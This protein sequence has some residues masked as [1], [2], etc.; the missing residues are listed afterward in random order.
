[1]KQGADPVTRPIMFA[2]N[3]GPGSAS[4]WLHM[5]ILG[6][7]LVDVADLEVNGAGPFR[8]IA[9]ATQLGA[10][11]GTSAEFWLAANFRVTEGQFT[12]ELLRGRG[13]LAGRIDSRFLG[14]TTNALAENMPF[15]PYMSAMAPAFVAAF[16]DYYRR[17]LGV[18]MDRDY[19]PSGDS[20][21]TWDRSHQDP[22]SPYKSAAADTGIDL[23]HA[24]VQNPRMKVLVQQGYFDLATPYRA[25][26]YFIDQLPI[27]DS[28]RANVAI[29][30][31]E[32]GHMM[33]VHPESRDQFRKDL[34][35][36]ID[37]SL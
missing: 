12:A 30:Y 8:R 32:A 25:T 36:F 37:S 34:A 4:M 13:Q 6:P 23:G 21:K 11:A 22:G 2:W 27:P 16:N 10:Y 29:R 1:V 14:Y 7:Q 35:G 18:V 9:V 15:D 5:G 3:G 28:L 17:D 33:Y 26:E 31:Y 24:L 19:V 20:Y